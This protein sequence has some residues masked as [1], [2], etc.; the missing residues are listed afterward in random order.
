LGRA[1]FEQFQPQEHY[2]PPSP[3]DSFREEKHME[4]NLRRSAENFIKRPSSYK[5]E[6]YSDQQQENSCVQQEKTEE[7]EYPTE[8]KES[9]KV[10]SSPKKSPKKEVK[11]KE[12]KKDGKKV[13]IKTPQDEDVLKKHQEFKPKAMKNEERPPFALFGWA[14]QILKTNLQW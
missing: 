1:V 2:S 6:A 5:P 7:E 9:S 12:I 8:E 13:Q 3:R 10:S 4:N 14:N 11:K